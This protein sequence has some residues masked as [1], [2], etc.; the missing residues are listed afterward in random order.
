MFSTITTT[1]ILS[2]K[3]W[4]QKRTM[5][6]IREGIEGGKGNDVIVL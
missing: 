2:E 1:A 4:T 3:P 5:R 6:G